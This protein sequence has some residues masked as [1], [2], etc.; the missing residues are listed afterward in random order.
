[1]ARQLLALRHGIIKTDWHL[2]GNNIDVLEMTVNRNITLTA[3]IVYGLIND[4]TDSQYWYDRHKR[5][6]TIIIRHSSGT[7][8]QRYEISATRQETQT[9]RLSNPI[10]II[11]D[12]GFTVMIP[13]PK[14]LVHYGSQCQEHWEENGIKVTFEY[15]PECTTDTNEK[16]GQIAGI[17]FTV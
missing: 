17:E 13:S 5:K 12:R 3:V 7:Y 2:D 16:Q 10:S 1:M 4:I 8:L 9:I 11:R 14:V 6:N 15:T